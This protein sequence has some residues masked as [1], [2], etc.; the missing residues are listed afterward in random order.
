M[1]KITTISFVRHGMV[2]NP[3]KIIYG[4]LP[5]FGLSKE[6]VSDALKAS[7]ILKKAPLKALYCSPLLRTRQTAKMILQHHPKLKLQ[8]SQLLHEVYTCH[9]GKKEESL[10]SLAGDVYANAQ[11]MYEQP[12]DI[13][14]RTLKFIQRI[15]KRYSGHHV[16]AVSHGDVVLFV[17][18]WVKGCEITPESKLQ[19]KTSGVLDEYPATGSITTLRYIS[20]SSGEI[21]DITYNN[22]SAVTLMR[23]L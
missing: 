18:L 19:L 2:Y 11:G 13:L 14:E 10:H 8:I 5:R 12:A 1:P 20:Q 17:Q 7:E 22:T 9:Q 4:R 21:P 23:G 15:R 16:A 3:E 6:G